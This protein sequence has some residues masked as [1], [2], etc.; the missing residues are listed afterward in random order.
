MILDITVPTLPESVPDALLLEWKKSPGSPVVRDEVLVE[1]ETDKVVLEVTAPQHGILKEILK[2]N[3][4]QVLAD[5]VIAR[6]EANA[7]ADSAP[8]GAADQS[9][10]SRAAAGEAALS[11]SVRKLVAEY[12]LDAQV[13]AGDIAGTGRDGRLTKGDVLAYLEER[14]SS[15]IMPQ[16]KQAARQPAPDLPPPPPPAFGNIGTD[17]GA[18]SRTERRVPL[19]RIRARIA[20][21]LV[22]AQQTAA[23]LT[24]FNEANLQA[25]MA[26]RKRFRA[27]FEEAHG[28][29]LGMMSFFVKAAVRALRQIPILNA[30]LEGAEVVHHDY[31]DIGV[32]VGSARG[33]VVPVL[34]DCDRLTFAEIEKKI[35]E[36]GEKANTA[37]LGIEDLSGGTFT[38]TNGGIFGS[39]MSTPILNPPQSAILGMHKIQERPVA[40]D[41]EVVIRP[42]MYLA[43]SYDHRLIDGQDAVR[44]LV[45]IKEAVEDPYRLL[46]DV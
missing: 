22:E 7:G 8:D 10:G 35:A 19:S 11:P 4:Q 18:P 20:E 21:R 34:R 17:S 13:A 40:E 3:G 15:P 5:D 14:K 44:F 37:Q 42:M 46:L 41:G 32:A 6:I 33:L 31:Y 45:A 36:F 27:P 1:L 39:L 12:G 26:L 25:V 9:A 29:R 28:A 23:I 38:I 24:T 30:S 2:E 16:G 43:L